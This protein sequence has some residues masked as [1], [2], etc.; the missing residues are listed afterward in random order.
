MRLFKI[1]WLDLLEESTQLI[2]IKR[3]FNLFIR[4]WIIKKQDYV[5]NGQQNSRFCCIIKLFGIL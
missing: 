1:G 5:S 4:L 2:K 3:I